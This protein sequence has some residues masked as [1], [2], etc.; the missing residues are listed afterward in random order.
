MH[1]T[2]R[3]LLATL[4]SAAAAGKLAHAQDEPVTIPG[5][6]PMIVH[7]DR[8]EDLETPVRYFDSWVTP[9]DAFFVRQHIPRPAPID[10]ESYRLTINGMVSKPLQLRLEELRNLTQYTIPATIECTGN[11]RGFYTPKVPGI[12]WLRGA[13][14]NAEWRGPRVSDV[15]KMASADASAAYIETDG[16]DVGLASTPDFVRSI[17]M[18][19]A[20]HPAT[21][22]ALSMN[23]Q[24][25]DIHGFPVRLIVPGWDGTSS[26]KWVIRISVAAQPNNGFFMNPG[27]RYPKY[28]LT[29]GTP[30]KPSELEVIEGMPVK[31]SITSPE[32]Q[33]KTTLGS[34]PIRGFAWAG[35][36]TIERVEVSTDGG[37]RWRDAELSNPKLP[38]AWRLFHLDWRP[39][40]PGYYTILSRA[41][42]SAGRVQPFV[43]AW[44][45]SGYLY[46]A[47]DRV[48][49]TV[50]RPA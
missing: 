8:P 35:E 40:D 42:D 24:S 9:N 14:G 12:Q 29:P 11:G 20:M 36:Q 21:I 6:R 22:L 47:V 33:S 4:F 45:P 39:G 13:I 28:G 48:G 26:V 23:G 31:S 38:F 15:L 43:A 3:D 5:K 10:R 27:Y 25:P 19:K 18:S 32:D 1:S 7:N 2:R 37:S 44:N 17:P 50:E 16:A 41:T 46:N 34:I 30:A 49:V